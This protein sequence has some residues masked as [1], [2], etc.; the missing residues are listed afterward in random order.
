MHDPAVAVADFE[1][2]DRF[3]V[4][5]VG[6]REDLPEVIAVSCANHYFPGDPSPLS[7]PAAA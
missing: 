2:C 3:S 7:Y 1:G 5:V 6:W 4:V